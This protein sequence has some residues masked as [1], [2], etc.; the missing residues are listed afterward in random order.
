MAKTLLTARPT[1]SSTTPP[2]SPGRTKRFKSVRVRQR[3]AGGG[4]PPAAGGAT[5]IVLMATLKVSGYAYG[6]QPHI[7]VGF[8]PHD[9]ME[10]AVPPKLPAGPVWSQ[11]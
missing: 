4:N 1:A 7:I 9:A 8:T 3:A 6:V 5:G 10:I 11:N 2:R